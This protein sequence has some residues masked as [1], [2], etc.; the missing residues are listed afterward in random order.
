MSREFRGLRQSRCLAP[1]SVYAWAAVA[2]LRGDWLDGRTLALFHDEHRLEGPLATVLY[3]PVITALRR[4][5]HEHL[6]T[7]IVRKGKKTAK[8]RRS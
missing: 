7:E 5:L 2:K 1:T 6:T 8:R 4:L 3:E